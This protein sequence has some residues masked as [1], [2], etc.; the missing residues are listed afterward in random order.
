MCILVINIG[1]VAFFYIFTTV[2]VLLSADVFP[3]DSRI[4]S[5]IFKINCLISLGDVSI[6]FA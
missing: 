3:S 1:F 6:V 2:L 5:L 4:S